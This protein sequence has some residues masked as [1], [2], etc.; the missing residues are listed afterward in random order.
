MNQDSITYIKNSAKELIETFFKESNKRSQQIVVYTDD[1]GDPALINM[2]GVQ[3]MHVCGSN[4]RVI[5]EDGLSIDIQYGSHEGC[6][7][8]MLNLLE[9]MPE[10]NKY[11]D[12]YLFKEGLLVSPYNKTPKNKYMDSED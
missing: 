10:M 2:E 1:S 3:S 4:I 8:S 11:T 5:R 6:R 7:A 12:S 9:A